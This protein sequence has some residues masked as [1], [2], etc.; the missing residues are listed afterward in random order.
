M[1]DIEKNTGTIRDKNRNYLVFVFKS[2]INN[3]PQASLVQWDVNHI[4]ISINHADKNTIEIHNQ[5]AYT[6]IIIK[7][8][9]FFSSLTKRMNKN[10]INFDNKKIKKTTF[11]IKI[12][13]YLI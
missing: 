13:E 8:F 4:S 5:C 3:T 12:K 6:I 9:Y 2:V 7:S 11:T 10:N 1:L